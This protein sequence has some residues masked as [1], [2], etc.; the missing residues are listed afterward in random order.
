MVLSGRQLWL[1]KFIRRAVIASDGFHRMNKRYFGKAN[2]LSRM[3]MEIGQIV[4]SL[5]IV[6]NTKNPLDDPSQKI[7]YWRQLGS[8]SKFGEK[9]KKLIEPFMTV[10]ISPFG[11]QRKP[12]AN[13]VIEQKAQ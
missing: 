10:L 13:Q 1:E 11:S 4:E 3:G 12:S 6:P 7:L 5:T 9:F 2:R 8:Q